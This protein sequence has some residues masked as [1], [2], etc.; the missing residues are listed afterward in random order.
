V[1]AVW[2]D[3]DRLVP[4]E[5]RRG[6]GVA[7]PQAQ[8]D[9]WAGMGHHPTRERFDDLVALVR[10]AMVAAPRSAQPKAA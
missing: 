6:V 9:L 1:Y 2:G 7:F 4:V 10:R 8:I 3:R 5:H